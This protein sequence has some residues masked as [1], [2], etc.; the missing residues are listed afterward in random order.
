MFNHSTVKFKDHVYISQHFSYNTNDLYQT[1]KFIRYQ[2]SRTHS[3]ST[4]MAE[5]C[6]IYLFY[7]LTSNLLKYFCTSINVRVFTYPNSSYN[8]GDLYQ[9][10]KFMFTNFQD[11]SLH[12]SASTLIAMMRTTWHLSVNRSA[13]SLCCLL[14]NSLSSTRPE[15]GFSSG[16]TSRNTSDALH[17]S[18]L[19]PLC[20]PK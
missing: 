1:I 10:I 16:Y 18:M 5:Q 19:L 8:T 17:R 13:I 11:S 7:K 9:I 14:R 15:P 2:H 4:L 12:L 20:K 3:V 6:R